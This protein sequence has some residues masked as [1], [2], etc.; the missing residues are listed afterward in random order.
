M[1]L[2]SFATAMGSG[3]SHV[4]RSQNENKPSDDKHE[5]HQPWLQT[6]RH[7]FPTPITPSFFA[8]P[9]RRSFLQQLKRSLPLGV[10]VSQAAPPQEYGIQAPSDPWVPT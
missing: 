3:C 6:I 1:I 4:L 2:P 5:P 7:T 9:P 8:H 10:G